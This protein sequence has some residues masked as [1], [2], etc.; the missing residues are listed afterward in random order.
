MLQGY[1]KEHGSGGRPA[2]AAVLRGTE[3]YWPPAVAILGVRVMR[4][5][6][7]FST[8]LKKNINLPHPWDGNK[9]GVQ[10]NKEKLLSR[11]TRRKLLL[12]QWRRTKKK[13][14]R[15]A[16]RACF[17]SSHP[18]SFIKP[19]REQ[20]HEGQKRGSPG[21]RQHPHVGVPTLGDPWVGSLQSVPRFSPNHPGTQH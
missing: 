14:A 19:Q 10:Q 18:V 11:L 2:S 1:P 4:E 8:A 7:M 15:Y 3:R 6:G 17:P 5:A 9:V 16:S 13:C 20:L 12:E 21:V